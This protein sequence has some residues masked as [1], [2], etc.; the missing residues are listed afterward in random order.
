LVE[1]HR[2]R[3]TTADLLRVARASL[4]AASSVLTEGSE[5][6]TSTALR[7][8]FRG[9]VLELL[10]RDFIGALLVGAVGGRRVV[11]SERT[12]CRGAVRG[13]SV[14]ADE[15]VVARGSRQFG[16]RCGD[17]RR[18]GTINGIQSRSTTDFGRVAGAHVH[19]AC[20]RGCIDARKGV[21]FAAP[22]CRRG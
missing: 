16:R 5:F 1:C 18:V 7:A 9:E 19:A 14:A 8:V 20:V 10:R 3:I 11:A 17:L 21:C 12:A 13:I 2:V 6:V 22:A 15:G 4:V